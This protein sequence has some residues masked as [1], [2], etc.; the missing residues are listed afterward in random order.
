LVTVASTSDVA[1][2]V[3]DDLLGAE[4]SHVTGDQRSYW[5]RAPHSAGVTIDAYVDGAP[6]DAVNPSPWV[7]HEVVCH[8]D[9]LAFANVGT[10][11]GEIGTAGA[12]G[13]LI[14][15]ANTALGAGVAFDGARLFLQEQIVDVASGT[16]D[17]GIIMAG[18]F[19]SS[20][21]AMLTWTRG[22]GVS[23]SDPLMGLS[24]AGGTTELFAVA[25][26]GIIRAPVTDP[27]LDYALAG[28]VTGAGIALQVGNN[29]TAISGVVGF[30]EQGLGPATLGDGRDGLTLGDLGLVD[31]LRIR[32]DV[33][34]RTLALERAGL[35]ANIVFAVSGA[36]EAC[37]N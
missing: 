33:D 37:R 15:T 34:A 10:F 19:S 26:D 7:D 18:R 9:D 24:R 30:D 21:T 14:P 3:G 36:R 32:E 5:V 6:V 29:R 35:T 31:E 27:S 25:S 13:Q 1:F 20:D 4:L 12:R 23:A 8:F 11:G 28:R 2:Y 22:G 16:P 17:L